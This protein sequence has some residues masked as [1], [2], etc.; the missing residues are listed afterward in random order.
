M[1]DQFKRGRGRP[2]GPQKTALSLRVTTEFRAKLEASAIA[3]GRSL[4]GEA[5]HL[6]SQGLRDGELLQ[7]I[8]ALRLFVEGA[9]N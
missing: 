3:S 9:G 2:V 7:E 6:L 1:G 5:E 8:R 4:S